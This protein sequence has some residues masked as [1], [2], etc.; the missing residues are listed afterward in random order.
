MFVKRQASIEQ[1]S[2]IDWNDVNLE[3][4]SGHPEKSLKPNGFEDWVIEESSKFTH[5]DRAMSPKF[6]QQRIALN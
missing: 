1:N 3:L 4:I 2:G 5:V 6:N